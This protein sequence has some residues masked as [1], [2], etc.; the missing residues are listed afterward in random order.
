MIVIKAILEVPEEPR[1]IRRVPM[2]RLP[3]E[4]TFDEVMLP[5][6]HTCQVVCLRLTSSWTAR[7]QKLCIMLHRLFKPHLSSVG[8][9][10]MKYED[11][12]KDLIILDSDIDISHALSLSNVLKVYVSGI[13]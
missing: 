6:I 2:S 3:G 9:I 13:L 1:E 7:K 5:Y 12:D 8:N 10:C 11:E 4:L